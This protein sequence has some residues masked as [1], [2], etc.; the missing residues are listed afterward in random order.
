MIKVTG[1]TK[2]GNKQEAK[3]E[4]AAAIFGVIPNHELLQ[5]AYRAYLANGR[6]ASPRTLTR[7][8]VSGGGK[9]PWRQKGTGRARVGSSRVPNWRGGGVTFGPTGLQNHVTN[10]P[11]K[12]KRLA[13]RQALSA[14]AGEGRLHVIESFEIR[15]GKT[16]ETATLL[17]KLK[18]NGKVLLVI[19]ERTDLINRATDNM[20]ALEVVAAGYLNV[21]TILN[22]D[23][24]V[25]TKLAIEKIE[26]WLSEPKPVL[27]E[28]KPKPKAAKEAKHE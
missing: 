2:S 18:L 12:M 14:Q 1:Y 26:S 11:V 6:S 9:K 5:L 15:E 16:K 28:P 27:A 24:I 10:L 17:N 22:A 8:L 19:D 4:L 23:H 3:V 13:I 7:G 21:F 20:T 25:I